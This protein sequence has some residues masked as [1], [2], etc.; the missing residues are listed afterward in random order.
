MYT[1]HEEVPVYEIRKGELEANHYNRVQTAHKRL[2]KDLRL[3]IPGLRTLDLLLQPEAW[4]VVDRA[5]NDI[6]IIAW[7]HFETEHRTSLH[8]PVR[9]RIRLYHANAGIIL[10]RVIEAME[11][12]LGERLDD[13]SGSEMAGIIPFRRSQ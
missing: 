13:G 5:L 8:L 1:R 6:P 11:L 4:I 3:E 10:Q 12:L 2:G 9:C 7:S